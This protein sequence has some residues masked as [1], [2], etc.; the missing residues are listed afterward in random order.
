M[1]YFHYYEKSGMFHGSLPSVMGTRLDGLLFGPGKDYL[2]D[3]WNHAVYEL[4]KLQNMMN[5]F[6]PV[7]EISLLKKNALSTPA[8]MSDELWEVLLNCGKYHTLT[9]GLFDI[10]LSDFKKIEFDHKQ[11]TIFF[12]GNPVILDLGGYAKGYAM[13][14]IRKLLIDAGINQAFFNFGN[15][16]VMALGK[17]PGGRPW[18]VGIDNPFFPGEQLGSA[19]L[20]D[21]ALSSSGNL[22]EHRQHIVHPH[23]GDFYSGKRVVSVL[24]G[25]DSEAEI[26]S[27]ALLLADDKTAEEIKG[28]FNNITVYIYRIP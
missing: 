5:H 4:M 2:N 20:C 17:H 23:T 25:S 28:N 18:L 26:L 21:N 12:H 14:K 13:Q 1:S 11:K 10:T 8:G 7:S 3:I 22:P 9:S 6:D 19:E 27:T 24:S 16:S 15:S